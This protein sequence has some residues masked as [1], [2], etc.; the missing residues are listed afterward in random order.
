MAGQ[1]SSGRFGGS[2]GDFRSGS[3]NKSESGTVCTA[4]D[5]IPTS[6]ADPTIG[7]GSPVPTRTDMGI[8]RMMLLRVLALPMVELKVSSDCIGMHTNWHN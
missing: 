4:I 7:G 5:T 8:G 1:N 3:E 2:K 6:S